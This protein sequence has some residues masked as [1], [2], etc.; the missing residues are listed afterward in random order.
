MSAPLDAFIP[1]PDIRERFHVTIGASAA[2]VM[3]EACALDLQALPLARFVF[4]LRE[5]LMG[6]PP[7]G[8]RRPQGLL[9]E[10]QSLGWGMLIN[11]P[12][13]LIVC[14]AVCQPW[15]AEVTFRPIPV[16]E[17]ADYTEPNQVKIAW[18]LEA[19]ALGP[20][21]T[22]FAHET[23]AVAT[24][25]EARRHFARYWRWARVGIIGIRLLLL[26]AIRRNAE[27][28]WLDTGGGAITDD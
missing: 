11:T 25:P 21:R 16:E 17:F 5:R 19:E 13:S 20:D 26:P 1:N 3:E 14:G 23:R 22:R 15:L 8:P 2:V 27:R 10:T 4:W 7:A 9:A 12:P 18:T 24:D 6:A 28:R